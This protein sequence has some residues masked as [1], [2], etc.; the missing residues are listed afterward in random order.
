[1]PSNIHVYNNKEELSR[2]VVARLENAAVTAMAERSRCAI[3]LAGGSTPR[4][5]YA[6][7]S[8]SKKTD[9]S[10]VHF[11]WSD[12]RCVIST[13]PDS[14]FHMATEALLSKIKIPQSN[15]HRVPAEEDPMLASQQYEDEIRDFFG[16][17]S[18]EPPVFDV[19]LLG[20]GEDGH[21]A[22]IFPG[23][24]AV[25]VADS[26]VADNFVKKL[27]SHR[28]TFTLP[29]INQA[30]VVAFVVTG[31]AKAAAL[32]DVLKKGPSSGLPAALVNPV[33]GQLEWYVDKEAAGQIA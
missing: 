13:H 11:F 30:R 1:M 32:A 10:K 3:A 6:E 18:S 5:V 21:T 17:R 14:N 33:H 29:L 27:Q 16:A 24:D 9:W 22:S 12:E 31:T 7:W 26:W 28:I 2:A 23:T 25:D 20:M 8:L 15:I 19:I 4:A